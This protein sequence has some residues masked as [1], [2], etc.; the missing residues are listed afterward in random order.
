MLAV[1]EDK[2]FVFSNRWWT[3]NNQTIIW[4]SLLLLYRK[5]FLLYFFGGKKC[6]QSIF[7]FCKPF[8]FFLYSWGFFVAK[9]TLYV[10][11]SNLNLCSLLVTNQYDCISLSFPSL[12][13]PNKLACN[14]RSVDRWVLGHTVIPWDRQSRVPRKCCLA[15]NYTP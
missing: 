3:R 10:F 7:E 1:W 8:C 11:H 2:A 14:H 6:M 5:I 12:S 13:D 15:Q 4:I 9:L